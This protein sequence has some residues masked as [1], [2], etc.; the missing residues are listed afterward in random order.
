MGVLPCSPEFPRR[1]RSM[2]ENLAVEKTTWLHQLTRRNTRA[3]LSRRIALG[4]QVLIAVI[5]GIANELN[6]LW[7]AAGLT[8][9]W[10]SALAASRRELIYILGSLRS[11][12]LQ[13]AFNWR[14]Q[15]TIGIWRG[16]TIARPVSVLVG[17]AFVTVI[18]AAAL[19]VSLIIYLSVRRCL[20]PRRIA[21]GLLGGLATFSVGWIGGAVL[22]IH[23]AHGFR[24][25]LVL[26]MPLFFSLLVSLWVVRPTTKIIRATTI[27]E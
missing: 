1:G 11:R 4:S 10:I 14:S 16:A 2:A 26:S 18:V 6:I 7:V 8:A 15:S 22:P 25:Y 9:V 17:I 23:R 20:R 13:A 21:Q 3:L 24:G 27:S 5:V 12:S 19:L